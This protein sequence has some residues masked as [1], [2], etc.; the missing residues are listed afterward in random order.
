MDA[1]LHAFTSG[2]IGIF[3][4]GMMARVSWGHTGRNIAETLPI[5]PAIFLLIVA[6]ALIRVL[7]TLFNQPNFGVWI[8]V[9][10]ILWMSAFVLYL[11]S[12]FSVLTS[13]R[14]DGKLG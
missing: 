5:L 9:S 12:Y 3:T 4:L 1:A 6:S 7:F 2:G 11:I 14:M 13:P 10:Q 8:G